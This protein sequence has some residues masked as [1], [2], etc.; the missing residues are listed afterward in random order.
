MCWLRS[1]G[2]TVN[3]KKVKFA[4]T[5]IS[6][7]G[8][9]ISYKGVTVDPERTQGI[10]DFLPPKDAKGIGRFVG[11]VNLYRRFIPNAAEIAAPLNELHKKG[12]KFEWGEK[13]RKAFE[14]LKEAIISPPVTDARFF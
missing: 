1:A 3:P 5:Q 2:L 7:L 8:H 13:Q 11:M 14:A 4:Q 10:R 12:A 6:F 9:L